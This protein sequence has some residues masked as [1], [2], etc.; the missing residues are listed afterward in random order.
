MSSHDHD[1]QQEHATVQI[2]VE[3]H[4]R[5]HHH[6]THDLCPRCHSLLEYSHR[7]LR[8][9]RYGNKKPFCSQCPTHCYRPD[10]RKRLRKAMRYSGPRMLF[11]HPKMAV[12]HLMTRFKKPKLPPPQH[13]DSPSIT[14]DSPDDPTAEK[15][16]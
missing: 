4:C 13:T 8:Q 9:C 7:R 10:M 14:D 12:R 1:L 5:A 2:M 15:D 16:L 6:P 11:S 3:K